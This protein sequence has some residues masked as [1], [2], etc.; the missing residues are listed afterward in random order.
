MVHHY[1]R[2]LQNI[3]KQCTN[4]LQPLNSDLKHKRNTLIAAKT[5][6]SS[7]EHHGK[8]EHAQGKWQHS[9]LFSSLFIKRLNHLFPNMKPSYYK[10]IFGRNVI[11]KA[12]KLNIICILLTVSISVSKH[13]IC[14]VLKYIY[15]LRSIL[16]WSTYSV[17][18][19]KLKLS[20]HERIPN[21]TVT[22]FVLL[23]P[24]G[25]IYTHPLCYLGAETSPNPAHRLYIVTTKFLLKRAWF[26]NSK[27]KLHIK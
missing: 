16:D 1:S 7:V 2:P 3:I 11:L 9:M 4:T 23:L 20:T 6:S 25:K 24:F 17:L 15:T 19:N 18:R 8:E 26:K 21:I 5:F 14:V 27:P 12:D 22:Y 13:Y 10:G